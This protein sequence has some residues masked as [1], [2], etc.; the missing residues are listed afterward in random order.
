MTALLTYVVINY[1]LLLDKAR[2]SGR[3]VKMPTF[4]TKPYSANNQPLTVPEQLL[5]GPCRT[6]NLPKRV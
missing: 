1:L 3:Q 6:P 4:K 2:I 5:F